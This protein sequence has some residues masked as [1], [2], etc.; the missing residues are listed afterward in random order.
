LAYTHGTWMGEE[1][2]AL[3]VGFPRPSDDPEWRP[4]TKTTVE[5]WGTKDT[6]ATTTSWTKIHLNFDITFGG[7]TA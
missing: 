4:L 2:D 7:I 6:S 5:C 3:V 1:I